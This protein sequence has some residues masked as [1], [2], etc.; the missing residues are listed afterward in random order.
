MDT[1]GG[2]PALLPGHTWSAL[3]RAL[4]LSTRELEI[5]I[6]MIENRLETDEQIA[7]ALGI[8]P[9]TV[10]THLERLFRKLDVTSRSHL[11]LRVFSAYVREHDMDRHRT[12]A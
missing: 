11:I 9:H 1:K 10:H 8:S 4:R 5:V 12:P 6:C 3:A 7:A 2:T